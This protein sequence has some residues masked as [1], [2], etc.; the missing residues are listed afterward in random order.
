MQGRTEDMGGESRS[1]RE[2]N[3]A[4]TTQRLGEVVEVVLALRQADTG[5]GLAAAARRA[6]VRG[7]V[8]EQGL[9]LRG[10]ARC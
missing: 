5:A 8:D 2:T 3:G 9:V 1:T 4:R 7:L 6:L 10:S